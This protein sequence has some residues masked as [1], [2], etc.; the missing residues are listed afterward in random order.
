MDMDIA[1]KGVV[2]TADLLRTRKVGTVTFNVCVK[3]CVAQGSSIGSATRDEYKLEK[4][5]GEVA[6]LSDAC[7][8]GLVG[9][10]PSR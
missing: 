6:A 3:S 9:S 8:T 2:M 5:T 7:N 1:G 4:L 10:E